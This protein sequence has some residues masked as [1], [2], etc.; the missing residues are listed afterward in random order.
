LGCELAAP[1]PARELVQTDPK[2]RETTLAGVYSVGDAAGGPG[3]SVILDASSDATAAYALNHAL[4]KQDAEDEVAAATA[5][6]LG[7]GRATG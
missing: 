3:Q 6:E 7:L 5:A 2:T 1:V 4:A